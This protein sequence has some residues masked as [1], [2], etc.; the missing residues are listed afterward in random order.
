MTSEIMEHSTRSPSGAHGWRRCPAKINAELGFP[1]NARIEAAHG[2][3]FHDHAEVSL[4]GAIHPLELPLGDKRE[5]NGYEVEFTEEMAEDM[6]NGFEFVMSVM[7]E[8]PDAILFV[9]ERVDI[10]YWTLEDGGFG[11]SDCCIVIPSLRLI[12]VFDWK[13]GNVPVSPIENDQLRLYGLGC[14]QSLAGALFDW[15]ATGIDVHL[16]I[17][18]PRVPGAGGRWETTMEELLDEGTQIMIDA[19]A[20]YAPNAPRI[21][22]EKQ[23]RYCKVRTICSTNAAHNMA[24]A[25]IKFSDI[26]EDIEWGNFGPTLPDPG[27]W[28]AEHRVYVWLHRNAF[29]AWLNA[30][31]DAIIDDLRA[32]KKLEY[33]KIVL[34]NAGNRAWRPSDEKRVRSAAL[35]LIGKKAVIEKIATPAQ[36]EKQ[37][38]KALGSKWGSEVYL[39]HFSDYVV[40]SDPKSKLVPATAPGEEVPSLLAQFDAVE[41]LEG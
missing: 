33:V 34:G 3:M 24:L 13:Y 41:E 40:Q 9:E 7:A 31:H 12:I 10:S 28:T 36:V 22:G 5:I 17:E 16:I 32:G 15:D 1:D 19:A 39:D 26:E 25:Q 23:C 18:Q 4:R 27:E 14:W 20:T 6:V 38:K 30:L 11:T 35:K 37:L 29:I 8:H 2:T 21:A